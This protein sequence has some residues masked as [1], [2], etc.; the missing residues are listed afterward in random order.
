MTRIFVAA[1]VMVQAVLPGVPFQ[2]WGP[3]GFSTVNAIE[4]SP[5]GRSMFVAL[6][7]AQV[8]KVEG[9]LPSSGAPEVALYESL[10][11]GD[12][13]SLP[14]LLPFAGIHKDYEATLSPDGATMIF[15]SWRPLP[16]GRAITNRKN[17]LWMTR[18]TASG[19][20]API[21]LAAINRI[22]TEESY[23]AIGPGGRM[24]FL[25]EGPADAHG[26]DYN[27]YATRIAGDGVD[28]AVPFAP[29]ATAAGESDPWY[30]RDGS[31]VIFTRWDR[32]KKWED[33]VDL[34]ITFDRGGQWTPPVPL[35]LNDP[36]GP[37]YALSIAGSPETVYWKRRGG[38]FYAPWAPILAAA[39][40]RAGLP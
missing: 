30:A 5:D 22:D 19:W 28:T 17:N 6:F 33:D 24:V 20:S 8:A 3:G 39:R 18:R 14:R 12:R 36:G 16:D 13:W 38:T 1:L 27:I 23:A 29:A 4:F 40:T 10:R 9:R 34:Y 32:A 35:S 21:Y 15:N 7:P 37:D 25:G 11:E 2:P 26:P 31:Y